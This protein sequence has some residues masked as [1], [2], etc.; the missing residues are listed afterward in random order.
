MSVREALAKLVQGQDLSRAEAQAAM[1]TLVAGEATPAQIAGF[2]IALRMKGETP[3]EIAGLAEVMRS[4]ATR[5][6]A[7]PNVVDVV[8]TGGDGADTLNISTMSALIVAS[9]G[10]RVA[11]HGNRSVTSQCGAA[12]FLE[13]IG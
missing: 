12:D 1:R 7:G 8:G 4:A 11:K 5:V 2:M 10:G 9:A 13:A 3:E 6:H